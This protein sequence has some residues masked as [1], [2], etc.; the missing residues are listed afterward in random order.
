MKML[1]LGKTGMEVSAL[2]LGAMY[3]GSRNDAATSYRILD[4]Y[5]G[6]GGSFI[7]TANIYAWWVEGFQGGE[8]ETLLGAWMAARGNRDQVFIASK[9][10]FGYMDVPKRLRARDIEQ[11]CEK[12]LRRLRTDRLDLFYAHVDDRQTP[13]EETMG[14]FDRLV[15]AGKVRTI[16]A[17]NY[18]AWRME[19]ARWTSETRGWASFCCVQ[20]HYTYLRLRP[21]M[22]VAPQEMVNDDLLDWLKARSITL[23]AYSVLQSGAYTRADRSLRRELQMPDN[24]RRLEVL[25][26]IAQE[27]GATAN[28]VILRWMMDRAII[29]LIA[30][31]SEEQMAENLGALNVTLS[32]EQTDRLNRAGTD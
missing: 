26:A 4:A 21:G 2:C 1:P 32:A 27:T 18:L 10:G 17:S 22:S 19:E 5:T 29:P 7:D 31:S 15:R 24:T 8:S 14:A 20:Q 30:A 16:G 3:F 25:R 6:A 12:S 11:E 9:V 28:Q 23:L 13:L